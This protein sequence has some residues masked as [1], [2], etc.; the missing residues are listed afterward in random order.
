MNSAMRFSSLGLALALVLSACGGNDSETTAIG[1]DG[2][3]TEIT[4]FWS[5]QRLAESEHPLDLVNQ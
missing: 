2:L 3:A 1:P 5:L 4:P